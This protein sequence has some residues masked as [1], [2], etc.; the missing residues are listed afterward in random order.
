MATRRD[1]LA[2]YT[3]ARK[4]TVAAFLAPSPGGSDEGAPR[5]IRTVMPSL[6]VGVVLVIGFIA[7]GVI[8]P[9]A[10]K[11]WDTP[12][13]HIIVD[14][15][16]TTR[17]V[18]IKDKA[19]NG[20]QVATLHP[21]LNYA[22]AKLLLDKGKGTV[23]EVP[24]KDID[25]SGIPHGATLGIPYA[26][27]RLPTKEDAEQEK[28]WAVCEQP[29]PGS[30]TAIDRA[31]FVLDGDDAKSVGNPG[32]VDAHEALYVVDT[33]TKLEYL[34]DGKGSAF[35]LGG[36]SGL[37]GTR[38]EDTRME[39]LRAAVFGTKADPQPVSTQWIQTLNRGGVIA[40]PTVPGI[41][42][43]TRVE[44]L[45]SEAQTV[46]R[47][48]KAQDAQG[49]QYYVVLEDRVAPVTSF[50]AALLTQSPSA[51]QAYGN[52]K[53]DY[54]KADTSAI[55][56]ANGGQADGFY[57]D[58]GWP[59]TVPQQANS[60]G[61]ATDAART[62]SCSVY[63]GTIGADQRPKLAA[64][65]GK[66]YPKKVIADSLSAYVSSGSGLLFQEVTGA[67]QGGG[68]TYLLTDTGLRYS[69]PSNND[70]AANKNG[71]GS[72]SEG[73][74]SE[75]DKARTRLGYEKLTRI[76]VVPKSWA[77]FIPKGPTLDTGSA[78]QPQSQ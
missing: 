10:P 16:S 47:V 78:A 27:D 62:T 69:L 66:T 39:Q 14:S 75:T 3:F 53:I 52:D 13:A 50:V 44:G 49:D 29:A 9:S 56:E 59:Q 72:A 24:G 40:F 68:G 5:P 15:D 22:S 48:L 55:I 65:A 23:I 42:G 1:E 43:Q 26:P 18:V 73:E 31:V 57:L 21:V 17:Y 38:T 4:R 28:T 2:A 70:S 19:E 33:R 76:A 61:T 36:T 58:K 41:G 77:E 51:P 35:V 11:G 25:K 45:P 6:A 32:K 54:I 67:A 60:A 63:S 74:P 46:G 12:G 8:K 20:K 37:G 7:W 64:W 30:N 34:I 71:A